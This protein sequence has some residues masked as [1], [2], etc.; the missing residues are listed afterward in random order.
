MKEAEDQT[1]GR[2]DDVGLRGVRVRRL[3]DRLSGAH[4]ADDDD[5]DDDDEDGRAS[6]Q[7][8]PKGDV[9]QHHRLCRTR[10]EFFASTSFIFAIFTPVVE[11]T[12]YYIVL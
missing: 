3:S 6:A 2:T 7:N 1:D 9:G 8:R 11:L 12:V 5:A 10:K 4:G